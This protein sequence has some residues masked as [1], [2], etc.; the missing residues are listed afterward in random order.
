MLGARVL[1]A[2]VLAP[3]VL[4]A[5]YLGGAP[6][7]A[8]VFVGSVL[9]LAELRNM[10]ARREVHLWFC[11]GVVASGLFA[12]SALAG[13]PIVL[14][15]IV[16]ASTMSTLAFPVLSRQSVL[17]T[18]VAATLYGILYVPYLASHVVLLRRLGVWPLALA[19]GAT[20][21]CDV[22]AYFAGKAFGRHK[23]LPRVSP[24][25]SW[26][27][28]I[29][30][31]LAATAFAVLAGRYALL[32]LSTSVV[33]GVLLGT[34]GQVGDLAESALKRYCGVKDSGSLIPGHGGVLDRFDSLL[35]NGTA[36]YYFLTLVK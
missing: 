29:A 11:A 1:G 5:A 9:G 16:A 13:N 26:E 15:C 18:D 12:A 31:V 30:G 20:W 34:V 19:I 22:F 14:L 10:L 2:F 4:G 35:F 28:T 8:L 33:A 25:K 3:V 7:S 17:Q 24:G 32:P 27:G 21:S 36:L 23:L 6:L